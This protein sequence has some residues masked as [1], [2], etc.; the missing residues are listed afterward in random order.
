[1]ICEASLICGNAVALGPILPVDIPTLF[2]W[3]DDVDAARL[4]ETYRPQNWHHQEAFWTNSDGDTSRVFF[5]IRA[6]GDPAIIGH[7]QIRAIDAIHRSASIGIRIGEPHLRG[8]GMGRDAMELAIRY[9]WDHLNLTR[10]G[11]S[12]FA[13][14]ERAVRLYTALGFRQEGVLRR[15]LFI[16]GRWIDLMLMALLHPDRI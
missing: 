7:V 4:N 1:L 14:N 10:L 5:A 11:L 12:V 2:R 16:D 6:L 3:S 9:C 13:G 8:Q 15:A